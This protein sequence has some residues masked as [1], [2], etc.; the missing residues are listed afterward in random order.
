MHVFRAARLKKDATSD[1]QKLQ[2]GSREVT[3]RSKE[4]RVGTDEQTLRRHLTADLASL[5]NTI[6]LD[7]VVDLEDTPYVA[8]S[9]INFG[10]GDMSEANDSLYARQQIS[11]LIR[12]TLIQHEPRLI[13][14]SIEIT[15]EVDGT[16]KDQRMSFEIQAEMVATPVD[17][18]LSFVAEV[19][20]GAGKLQMTQLRVQT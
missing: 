2:D 15:V 8:K 17:L 3:E 4:R 6:N 14:D 16:D 11:K 1:T 19:D 20:M 7:A 12:D 18:P 10:F 5:M 13:P 9:I